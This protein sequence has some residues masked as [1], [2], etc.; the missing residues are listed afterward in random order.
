MDDK[1]THIKIHNKG[2][3]YD[4]GEG[5]SFDS[6]GEL[7][8]YYKKCPLVDITGGVVHVKQ[9]GGWSW[10]DY[11]II[12]Y[13]RPLIVHSLYQLTLLTELKN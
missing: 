4:V 6:L 11:V 13:H 3:K 7:I 8:E 9:V 5:S 2:H 12:M 1:V 10:S